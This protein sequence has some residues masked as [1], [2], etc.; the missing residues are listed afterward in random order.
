MLFGL[1]GKPF[2]RFICNGIINISAQTSVDHDGVRIWLA[3]S[4]IGD[5]AGADC[6]CGSAQKALPC[7]F[8]AGIQLFLFFQPRISACRVRG[9]RFAER[10]GYPAI[11]LAFSS[12]FFHGAVTGHKMGRN[13]W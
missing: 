6:A 9:F 3:V 13:V 8:S 10:A 4:Q 7:S 12:A 5:T 1:S 2:D 11:F